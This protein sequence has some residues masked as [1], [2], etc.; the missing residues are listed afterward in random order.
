[1]SICATNNVLKETLYD[2]YNYMCQET[3]LLTQSH[4]ANTQIAPAIRAIINPQVC[5]F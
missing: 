3:H 5:V 1:M 4:S 2:F